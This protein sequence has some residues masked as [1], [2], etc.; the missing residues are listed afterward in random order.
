MIIRLHVQ[1]INY[2]RCFENLLPRIIEDF[3]RKADRSELEKL[4]VRLGSD[5]VPVMKKMLRYFNTDARDQLFLWLLEENQEAFVGTANEQLAKKFEGDAIVIGG[6]CG[7][8][9]PGPEMA[10]YA[11]DVNIDVEQL[12]NGPVLGGVLGGAAKMALMI[13]SPA[14][15]EKKGIKLLSSDLVKPALLSIL[16]D[17]LEGA[18]LILTLGDVELMD[19]GAADLP[20]PMVEPGKDEGLLPDEIEDRIIDAIAEWLRN[21]V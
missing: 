2:E 16:S 21:S 14:K 12:I 13:S 9:L 18:G 8:D 5:A 11:A 6:L 3:R 19:D 17:S 4:L 10:L 7:R 20:A 15:L 1:E